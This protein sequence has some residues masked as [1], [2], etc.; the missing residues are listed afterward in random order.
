[1]RSRLTLKRYLGHK[2]TW[3]VWLER[4]S[5]VGGILVFGLVIAGIRME[6]GL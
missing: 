2:A 1:M 3:V 6:L 4:A 5:I